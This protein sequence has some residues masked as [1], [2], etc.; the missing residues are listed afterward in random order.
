MRTTCP[1][2]ATGCQV[3]LV[4]KDGRIVDA[5]GADGPSN[6][7]LLCVKGRSGSF[8]FV[9]AP[10]RLTA[11]LVRNPATGELEETS[12]D[13]ALSVVARELGRIRDEHG[14][15]ALAAFACSRS[16][17]EDVYLFQ[18][19]ARTALHTHNVDNCARV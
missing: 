14:G 18:K 16:T 5:E 2:C 8:D 4:V 17:N 7:G 9:H 10:D 11:P 6:G 13:E 12:W 15:A 1:H 3:D 19:M